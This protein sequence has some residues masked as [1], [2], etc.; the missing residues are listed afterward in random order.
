RVA[1][2]QVTMIEAV[3]VH[4][5][6][7]LHSVIADAAFGDISD[8]GVEHAR[9]PGQRFIGE[10]RTFMRRPAPLAARHD[11]A[12]APELAALFDVIDVAAEG[13]SAVGPRLDEAG[14]QRFRAG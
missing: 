10:A 3:A 8:A 5:R 1:G 6:D 9:S 4:H 7:A 12:L 14:D 11:E 13:H 2:G